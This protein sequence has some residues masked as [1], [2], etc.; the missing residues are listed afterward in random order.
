M[1]VQVVEHG[2]LDVFPAKTTMKSDIRPFVFRV[3]A[4]S[5][6]LISWRKEIIQYSLTYRVHVIACPAIDCTDDEDMVCV[7][8]LIIDN[9]GV[10]TRFLEML[11]YSVHELQC[12]IS[13]VLAHQVCKGD[14]R[15][16]EVLGL[17][18]EINGSPEELWTKIRLLLALLLRE[19]LSR[20][21]GNFEPGEEQSRNGIESSQMQRYKAAKMSIWT[22]SSHAKYTETACSP[23]LALSNSYLGRAT[24]NYEPRSHKIRLATEIGGFVT[25]TRAFFVRIFL[26]MTLA[27]SIIV[28]LSILSTMAAIFSSAASMLMRCDEC[29]PFFMVCF[30][31]DMSD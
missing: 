9:A 4:K 31:P 30:A 7:P 6:V 11:V 29:S 2:F 23:A 8:C 20:K 3:L 5:E 21:T 1:R 22:Y 28:G 12:H 25:H 17:P 16:I 26:K 27:R 19:F 18:A 10:E 13:S 24:G 14:L 15:F